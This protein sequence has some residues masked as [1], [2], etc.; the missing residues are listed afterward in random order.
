MMATIYD[1][2][3]NTIYSRNKEEKG[4][5]QKIQSRYCAACG[6]NSLC[7][8]VKW[9]D[10]KIIFNSNYCFSFILGECGNG[11]RSAKTEKTES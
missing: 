8:V 2:I 7:Y 6:T 9:N 10:E 11:K 1:E 5:I 3:G 4:I